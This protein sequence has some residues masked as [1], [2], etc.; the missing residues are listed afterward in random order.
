MGSF[1]CEG[2]IYPVILPPP[3][4]AVS[5]GGS[6]QK[7]KCLRDQYC[8]WRPLRLCK[9][10]LALSAD[11]FLRQAHPSSDGNDPQSADVAL[12]SI[13]D[14]SIFNLFHE[15]QVLEWDRFTFVKW[16]LFSFVNSMYYF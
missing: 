15:L 8:R 16:F 14:R 5:A 12:K 7:P 11:D 2:P 9:I 6:Q 4:S 1:A 10:R 13:T 3:I